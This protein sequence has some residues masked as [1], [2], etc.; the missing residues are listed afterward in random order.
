MKSIVMALVYILCLVSCKVEEDDSS[1][2]ESKEYACCYDCPRVEEYY[3]SSSSLENE[4]ATC[5]TGNGG[6]WQRGRCSMTGVSELPKCVSEDSVAYYESNIS[7]FSLSIYKSFCLAI[8][9]G[10]GM[11]T[12]SNWYE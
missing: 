8:N 11:G 1:L 12:S 10:G 4:E 3:I 9:S 6:T 5:V 2:T 7:A